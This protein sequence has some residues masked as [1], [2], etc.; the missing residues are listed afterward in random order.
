MDWSLSQEDPLEWEAATHSS[1]LPGKSHGQRRLAGY[2]PWGCKRVRHDLATKQ[3]QQQQFSPK[4]HSHPGTTTTLPQTPLP[5]RL[6]HNTVPSAI[7]CH[8][9]TFCN[10]SSG[11]Q[12]VSG[13][14]FAGQVV[15]GRRPGELI[16]PWRNDLSLYRNDSIYNSSFIISTMLSATAVLI[17]WL[18]LMCSVS[19]ELRSE[20]TRKGI[21]FGIERLIINS[22]RGLSFTGTVIQHVRLPPKH[23]T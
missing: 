4:L 23:N 16:L 15:H 18:W 20:G 9:L 6:P 19:V 2:S 1:T 3:Q 22:V 10:R 13:L 8:F 11:S 21:E 7:L 17:T 14:W 5:S 12:N